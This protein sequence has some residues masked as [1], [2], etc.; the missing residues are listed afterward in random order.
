MLP[1]DLHAKIF[2]RCGQHRDTNAC[3]HSSAFDCRQMVVLSFGFHGKGQK[4]K[5]PKK[6]PA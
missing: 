5:H 1:S 6:C 2:S 4:E 3:I